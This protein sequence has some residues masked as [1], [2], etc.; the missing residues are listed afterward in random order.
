VTPST[1]SVGPTEGLEADKLPADFTAKYAGVLVYEWWKT[2]LEET[3]C[4]HRT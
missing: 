1:P 3:R 4:R 2:Y